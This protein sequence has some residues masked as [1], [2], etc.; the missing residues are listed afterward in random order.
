MAGFKVFLVAKVKCRKT[1]TQDARR[2]FFRD[3]ANVYNNLGFVMASGL[4]GICMFFDLMFFYE[5][6][7]PK[8]Q[9]G[10]IGNYTVLMT[11]F[12]FFGVSPVA[13]N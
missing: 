10:I 12:Y 11:F 2:G 6:Y 9:S 5:I 4:V 1:F 13:G 8:D 3:I 7:T